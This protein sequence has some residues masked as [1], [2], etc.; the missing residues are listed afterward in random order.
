MSV[1][2]EVLPFLQPEKNTVTVFWTV[3]VIYLENTGL[4][5]ILTLCSWMSL[6]LTNPIVLPSHYPKHS[7][8]NFASCKNAID[9]IY[10]LWV[11]E[12]R[13]LT[14]LTFTLNFTTKLSLYK[15]NLINI[16]RKAYFL[17]RRLFFFLLEDFF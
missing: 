13:K 5:M 10:F 12:I 15:L 11:C 3:F 7:N 6:N 16:G 9:S 2:I 8:C 4:K 14:I 1:F 17:K